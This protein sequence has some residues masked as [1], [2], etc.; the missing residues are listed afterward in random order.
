M[1]KRIGCV[2][3]LCFFGCGPVQVEHPPLA[4]SKQALS[5]T[6]VISQVYGGGGNTGAPFQNDFIELHNVS[7]VPVNVS[8][9]SVQYTSS[10]GTLWQVTTI[11]NGTTIP[12]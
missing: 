10:A 12:A 4:R 7:T 2:G 6:V 9:W 8:G 1:L 5:T 11:P 3:V